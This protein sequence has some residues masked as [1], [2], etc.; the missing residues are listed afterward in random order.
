MS[1]DLS[2]IQREILLEEIDKWI[3]INKDELLRSRTEIS[4]I[5]RQEIN[6]GIL[7]QNIIVVGIS[8]GA[9]VALAIWLVFEYTLGGI[10]C[11]SG[12]PPFSQKELLNQKSQKDVKTPVLVYHGEKDIIVPYWIVKKY[13]K[14]LGIE[15][16]NYPYGHELD[17]EVFKEAINFS[18]KAFSEREI[19]FDDKEILTGTKP[20]EDNS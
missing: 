3:K 19:D 7:P 11:M 12:F 6:L 2:K 5:I 10:I 13:T 14:I 4:E 9:S 16:K 18:K 17:E 1:G 20:H 15:P 8:Q